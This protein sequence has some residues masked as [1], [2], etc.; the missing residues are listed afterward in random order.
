MRMPPA[1]GIYEVL[2]GAVPLNKVL[3][4]DPRS[5]AFVLT[6]ARQPPNMSTMFGSG[7]MKKL[8]RL[9]RDSCDMVV[10]DCGRAAAPETWLLARLCDATLLVSRKDVL[11]T[12]GLAKSVQHPATP[13]KSRRWD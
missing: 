12:P 9:L 7:Q 10:M 2:T 8:I 5:D 13:P 3:A 6:M 4:S 1:G 11:N